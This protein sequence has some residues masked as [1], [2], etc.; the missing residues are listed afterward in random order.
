MKRARETSQLT[1]WT[2]HPSQVVDSALTAYADS[3][4]K[5]SK[6]MSMQEKDKSGIV[7]NPIGEDELIRQL[8]QEIELEGIE[9][10][11]VLV[12]SSA[13]S[14]LVPS[15]SFSFAFIKLNNLSISRRIIAFVLGVGKSISNF[16][17]KQSICVFR[18]FS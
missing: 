13:G 18:L 2:E 9:N 8:E 5:K 4:A 6:V 17:L 7:G 15:M 16:S 3:L 10:L 14:G 11:L 1:W 12:D